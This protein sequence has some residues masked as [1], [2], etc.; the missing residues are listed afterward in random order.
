MTYDF[1]RAILLI[2]FLV[3]FQLLVQTGVEVIPAGLLMKRWTRDAKD[4][5]DDVA[6]PFGSTDHMPSTSTN[7]LHA[8]MHAS[9]ME[10][11]HMCSSSRQAFDLALDFIARAKHAVS[12]MTV[13]DGDVTR[14]DEEDIANK[15]QT[16]NADA[17]EGVSDMLNDA[18]APPRVRSR[19]RPA[20]SHIKS[21][22][23]VAPKAG[24]T[25]AHSSQ[26]KRKASGAC[27]STPGSS[28]GVE[29][30]ICGSSEHLAADCSDSNAAVNKGKRRKCHAC[31]GEGHYHNTCGRRSSYSPCK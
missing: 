19:G 27:V 21:P 3:F 10:L 8:M 22:V 14:G 13:I 9:A 1:L 29:C 12:Q 16:A 11:V 25:S 31:G 26:G 30:S 28:G 18:A 2:V 24:R 7:S 6:V 5:L 4:L 17:S 20:T 15:N 23:E